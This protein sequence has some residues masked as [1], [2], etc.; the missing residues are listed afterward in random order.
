MKIGHTF[1]LMLVLLASP[2]YA[3]RDRIVTLEKDGSI[4]EIPASFGKVTLAINGLGTDA[5]TIT[6][7]I[8]SRTTTIPACMTGL[9][10]S[11]SRSD[12]KLTASWY[13]DEATLPYYLN[14]EFLDPGS[15]AKRGYNSSHSFLFNLH[16]GSLLKQK[17]FIANQTGTGGYSSEIKAPEGCDVEWTNN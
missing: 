17:K 6:L 7:G 3:H 11:K 1:L 16:N 9:I 12:V 10:H 14:V 5:V 4:P 15:S 8:G 13:H 2:A